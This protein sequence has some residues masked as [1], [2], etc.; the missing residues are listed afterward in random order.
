MRIALGIILLA[1]GVAYPM[2]ALY[3]LNLRMGRK[4]AMT[5]RQVGLQL[6]LNGILP[7]SL[8]FWGLALVLP[9]L[10]AS[11]AVRLVAGVTTLASLVII[12][13]QRAE[14]TGAAR[15]GAAGSGRAAATAAEGAAARTAG[16]AEGGNNGG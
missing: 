4:P 1:I 7:V 13:G 6:A 5:P 14:R 16:D 12:G 15:T 9:W 8:I 11:P 10:W 3:W 2:A